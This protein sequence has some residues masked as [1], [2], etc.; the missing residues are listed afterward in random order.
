[1]AS[2]NPEEGKSAPSKKQRFKTLFN[3][4]LD[5]KTFDAGAEI[6]LTKDQWAHLV[7]TGAIAGEWAN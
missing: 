2:D 6:A 3:V 5:G 7:Q 4:L 1:M